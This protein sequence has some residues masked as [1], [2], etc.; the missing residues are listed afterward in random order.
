MFDKY[1]YRVSILLENFSFVNFVIF[2]GA[3]DKPVVFKVI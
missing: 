1:R 3:D 2:E